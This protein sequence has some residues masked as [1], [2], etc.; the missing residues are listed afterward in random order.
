MPI[1]ACCA[2][3]R[4]WARAS[5]A[6]AWSRRCELDEA[7]AE[8]DPRAPRGLPRRRR[9]RRPRLSPRAAARRRLPRPVVPPPPLAPP[10]CRR[11][12]RARPRAPTSPRVAAD[13]THH[14]FEAGAVGESAPLRPLAGSAARAV[15]ANVDAA[16]VLDR[17][18]AAGARWRGARPEAVM[19]AAEALGDVRLV[20]RRV[21]ARAG[22]LRARAAR[23]SA[24]TPSSA[25]GC[26]AR[27]PSSP[28][29]SAPTPRA[30]RHPHGRARPAR[31]R[32]QRPRRPRSVRASRRCSGSSRCGAAGRASRWS[33]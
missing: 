7:A 9:R 5:R 33:G 15:Y 4:S 3:P 10:P 24:A 32:Q 28:T 26:C 2:R 18:V 29:G 23:A 22:C 31:R 13:L 16:A 19:L 6:P 25:P 20:A 30:E 21:R 8:D 11:V 1:A 14:F 12:A 17:A 27:R